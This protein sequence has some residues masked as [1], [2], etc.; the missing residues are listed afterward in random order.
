MGGLLFSYHLGRLFFRCPQCFHLQIQN[1]KTSIRTPFLSLF[2]LL[3]VI[4]K[5][6]KKSNNFYALHQPVFS[7]FHCEKLIILSE[8]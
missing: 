6:D 7:S 1:K 2:Q 5:L 8:K 4:Q 3:L